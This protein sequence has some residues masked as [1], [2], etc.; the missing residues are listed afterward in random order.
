MSAWKHH[1]FQVSLVTVT[2]EKQALILF[3]F[4]PEVLILE[5]SK[6]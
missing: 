3:E 4:C 1:L 5:I 2:D 6:A